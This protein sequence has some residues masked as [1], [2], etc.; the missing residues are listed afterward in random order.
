MGNGTYQ[1]ILEGVAEG[2][3]LQEVKEKLAAFFKMTPEKM[4]PSSKGNRSWSKRGWI[5]K[6]P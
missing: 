1:L 5:T 6:R 2:Y 3:D 4:I